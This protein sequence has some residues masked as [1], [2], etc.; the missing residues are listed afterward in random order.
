MTEAM[1]R[2]YSSKNY[3][4]TTWSKNVLLAVQVP[5]RCRTTNLSFYNAKIL[6]SCC[7]YRF[8]NNITEALEINRIAKKITLSNCNVD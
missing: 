8:A 1:M 4:I 3:T 5:C 2:D 6:C 7:C